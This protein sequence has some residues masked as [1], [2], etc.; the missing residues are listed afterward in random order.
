MEMEP[1]EYRQA[2]IEM[3]DR[4]YGY[5]LS[6]LREREEARDV[7]QEAFIRLWEHREGI[8][9]GAAARA[10][11]VRTAH[12]LCMDRLRQ[13]RTRRGLALEEIPEPAAPADSA[14]DR[15]SERRALADEVRRALDRLPPRDRALLILRE[16]HGRSYED[17]A[18]T[19]DVPIGTLKSLMHRARARL[20]RE[21]ERRRVAP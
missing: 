10:W 5:T 4:V 8:A 20:R 1:E 12:N 9:D 16:V 18:D 14:P 21:L 15:P 11:T 13:R 17:L 19:I 7:T 2:V 6:L 3:K